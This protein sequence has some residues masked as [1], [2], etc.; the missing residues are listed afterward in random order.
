VVNDSFFYVETVSELFDSIIFFGCFHHCSD[1]LRLLKS[2]HSALNCDGHVYFGQEP[3]QPDFPLPWGLRMDG[4]S[5]WAIRRNGWLELGFRT[6]YF[7]RAL[8]RTGWMSQTHASDFGVTIWDVWRNP[9][10][11]EACDPRLCTRNGN[12]YDGAI[13]FINSPPGYELWGPYIPLAQGAYTAVLYLQ[14]GT[15]RSGE[16]MIDACAAGGTKIFAANHFDFD[17]FSYADDMISLSFDLDQ[18]Y[19][20][21]E[22]RV[23]CKR[24]FTACIERLKISFGTFE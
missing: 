3:F 21:V 5:L 18:D 19:E 1:H 17:L 20:D 16:I 15:K 23:N 12:R 11:I 22:V 10:V 4:E 14:H 13:H 2:M 6:D 7:R 8:R 24:C 9:T